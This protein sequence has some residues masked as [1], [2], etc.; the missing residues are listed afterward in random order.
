[1]ITKIFFDD[2]N[3]VIISPKAIDFD[4]PKEFI[5]SLEHEIKS[6]IIRNES[7]TEYTTKNEISQLLLKY[8]YIND[9]HEHEKQ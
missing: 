6:M 3:D 9:S 7:L 4:L 8:L 2:K 1:M 5:K